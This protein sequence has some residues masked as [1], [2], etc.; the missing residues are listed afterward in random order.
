MKFHN[1][2]RGIKAENFFA[3]RMNKLG[4]NYSY[5][6][7]WYDFLVNKHK[8]E[9][10][11]CRLT[12]K[13]RNGEKESYRPGRFDFTKVSNRNLQ[14]KENIWICFIL[15]YEG[16]FLLLGFCKARQLKKKRYVQLHHLRKLKLLSLEK[17]VKE[18]N[19]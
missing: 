9:I 14:Y 5:E 2:E 11:S 18:V 7:D 6:D 19:C 12:V 1:K 16:F 3:S 4:L 13:Q 8:V 17:W 10:K 15:N